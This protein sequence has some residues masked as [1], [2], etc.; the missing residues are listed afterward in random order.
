MI[1]RGHDF[2]GDDDDKKPL[3]FLE[4]LKKAVFNCR[5]VQINYYFSQE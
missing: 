5:F 3:E 2:S 4:N 1:W